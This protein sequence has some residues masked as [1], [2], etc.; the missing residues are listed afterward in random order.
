MHIF[1]AG[2]GNNINETYL[3]VCRS[4]LNNVKKNVF[5]YNAEEPIVIQNN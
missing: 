1:H 2:N 5:I 3:L 4:Q